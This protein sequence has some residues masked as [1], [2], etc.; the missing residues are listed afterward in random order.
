MLAWYGLLLLATI[1]LNHDINVARRTNSR[2]A[3]YRAFVVFTFLVLRSVTVLTTRVRQSQT[4]IVGLFEAPTV[5][6]IFWL[7][8]LSIVVIALGA[9]P[10]EECC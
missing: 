5:A 7:V 6:H 1:A 9:C 3:K 2:M 10:T 8:V 4:I